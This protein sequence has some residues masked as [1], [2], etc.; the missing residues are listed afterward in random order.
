M[1]SAF[2]QIRSRNFSEHRNAALICAQVHSGCSL[3]ICFS[4]FVVLAPNVFHTNDMFVNYYNVV[5]TWA[6]QL[7]DHK[8]EP[9]VSGG[10]SLNLTDHRTRLSKLILHIANRSPYNTNPVRIGL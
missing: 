6:H 5:C 9:A 8:S 10:A 1:H 4:V 3:G 2:G 7:T